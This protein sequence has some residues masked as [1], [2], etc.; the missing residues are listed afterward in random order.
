M[1]YSWSDLMSL[2]VSGRLG[3]VDWAAIMVGDFGHCSTQSAMC[4]S[5]ITFVL[6]LNTCVCF[7]GREKEWTNITLQILTLLRWVVSSSHAFIH[8]SSWAS[9]LSQMGSCWIRTL[10]WIHPGDGFDVVTRA[11]IKWDV[12]HSV[13][14]NTICKESKFVMSDMLK[15]CPCVSLGL[16]HHSINGYWNTHPLRERARKLSQGILIIR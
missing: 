3:W 9:A 16:Q 10:S 4:N 11:R 7:R 8:H 2:C 6:V 15:L 13:M 5:L 12:S 14:N 1:V